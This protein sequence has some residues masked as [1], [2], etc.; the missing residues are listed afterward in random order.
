MQFVLNI[1]TFSRFLLRWCASCWPW[2]TEFRSSFPTWRTECIK[3]LQCF[4]PFRNCCLF[5]TFWIFRNCNSGD[6]Y[7][8]NYGKHS[9]NNHF[10]HSAHSVYKIYSVFKLFEFAVSF[11][12]FWLFR[13][14]Y[15]DDANHANY[16]KQS[17]DHH[18]RHG[19]HSVYRIYSALKLFDFAV[20]SAHF[21]FFE[22][23]TPVIRIMLAMANIVQ[24]IISD[25]AHTVNRR[26]TVFWTFSK[27]LFLL[28]ILT[29]SKLQLRWCA[30]CQLWQR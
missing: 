9:L 20:Y 26:F 23:T 5:C 10:R 29:F 2:Q 4:E 19:A 14:F 18:I 30:L 1:L 3:D 12:I 17:L 11:C 21:D 24:I 13:D 27:L 7:Y 16:G 22:V 8:F 25:M 6:A 15:S 28:H